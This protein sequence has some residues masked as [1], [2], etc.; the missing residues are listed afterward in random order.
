MEHSRSLNETGLSCSHCVEARYSRVENEGRGQQEPGCTRRI[1]VRR[2]SG[3]PL[4]S[5]ERE[6]VKILQAL[7][8]S[9][10]SNG[11]QPTEL[12]PSY[13]SCPLP[14]A[15]PADIVF[16]TAI[17]AD[18]DAWNTGAPEARSRLGRGEI[19]GI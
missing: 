10:V 17:S 12:P 1:A 19:R 3:T 5:D 8:T 7:G 14:A 18:H 15:L 6:S 4:A 11:A 16:T 9:S 2:G 13:T